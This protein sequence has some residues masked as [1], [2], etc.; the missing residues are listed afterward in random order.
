MGDTLRSPAFWVGF[1]VAFVVGSIVWPKL[2]RWW[3]SDA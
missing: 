1:V 2:L 3:R